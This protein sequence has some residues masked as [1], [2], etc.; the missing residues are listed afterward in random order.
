MSPTGLGPVI[1]QATD[2][3]GEGPPPS[4][5][6]L[7]WR[8]L[9]HWG[10]TPRPCRLCGGSTTLRDETGAACHKTCAEVALAAQLACAVVAA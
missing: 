10:P 2:P 1:G 6:K 8:A 5:V 9:K 3:A 7:D 4:T